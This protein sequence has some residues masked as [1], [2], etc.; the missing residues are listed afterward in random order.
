M[1]RPAALVT[2]ALLSSCAPDTPQRVYGPQ[3]NPRPGVGVLVNSTR[4]RCT[5]VLTR[6]EMERVCFP[7]KRRP[8]P[9]DS[10]GTDTMS[11]PAP[12]AR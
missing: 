1:L 8:E 2:L 4:G 3:P 6:G 7:R 5:W 10:I 11:A 9:R 12:S